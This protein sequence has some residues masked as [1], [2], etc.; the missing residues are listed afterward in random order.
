MS[1]FCLHIFNER[2][3]SEDIRAWNG[4]HADR[5]TAETLN[6]CK[7]WLEGKEHFE[8]KTS[9]STGVPKDIYI[10]RSQIETSALATIRF[11]DLQKGDAVCC[12]LS[13]HVIG[14]QMMLY[15]SIVGEL[16]LHVIP[17][18][19]NMEAL[20]TAIDYVFMPVAALQLFEVLN[21]HP[22]KISALNKLKHLLIGGSTLTDAL[23]IRIR[24]KLTCKVWQSYGMTETVS[25]VALRSIYPETSDS[26][27]LL[28]DIEAATD[29]RS[30]LKIKGAVTNNE[31]IQT[32]DCVKLLDETH[33]IFLGRTDFTVN[34]GGI[35]I[36]VE[37]IEK[38]I[39]ALFPELHIQAAFFV[40][41]IADNALGEKLILAV[42]SVV[43][44]DEKQQVIFK[45]L[46]ESLP[47]YH[48]PKEIRTLTFKYTSSGKIDRK[49]T[50]KIKNAD[51]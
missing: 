26:Y 7:L 21:K 38:I 20:D 6:Y 48:V 44:D 18:T 12:P 9:G 49:N 16:N 31:W 34:S 2:F 24:K 11:F 46:E 33:F 41:G 22:E 29:E 10:H 15:R 43:I 45:K 51:C 5:Y 30:C 36:Q 27:T 3:M 25:H 35:K 4:E 13:I 23:L 40:G 47:R 37:P 19:K 28:P 8:L 39:D 17:P 50:L 32:N 42:D 14:G 1:A